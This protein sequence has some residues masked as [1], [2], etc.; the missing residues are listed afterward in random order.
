LSKSVT[1]EAAPGGLYCECDRKHGLAGAYRSGQ[2]RILGASDEVAAC[3][4]K[5]FQPRDTPKGAQSI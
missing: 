2:D 4:F 3:Q 5:D 1:P